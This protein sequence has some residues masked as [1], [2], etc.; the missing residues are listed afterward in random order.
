MNN[1]IKIKGVYS[2]AAYLPSR[3]F[4]G[5][6]PTIDLFD[7]FS[8]HVILHIETEIEETPFSYELIRLPFFIDLIEFGQT[9]FSG[10]LFTIKLMDDARDNNSAELEQEGIYSADSY[11]YVVIVFMNSE[12]DRD[13]FINE[14][15]LIRKL[16]D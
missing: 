4:V 15:C 7:K 16:T 12:K 2:N 1:L 11:S 8:H 5:D 3:Y 10:R 6:D 9:R 13:I 14:W